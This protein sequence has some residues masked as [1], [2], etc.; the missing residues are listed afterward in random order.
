MTQDSTKTYS[1][2]G[3][4]LVPTI[5]DE[6]AEEHPESCVYIVPRTANFEDGF[7]DITWLQFA[8]AINSVARWIEENLGRSRTFETIAF[9][10]ATDFEYAVIT[11]A[12]QKAGY[13]VFSCPKKLRCLTHIT[14]GILLVALE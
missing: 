4:R 5:I 3:R 12:T 11:V 7:D 6:N 8:N 2:L 1:N 13:K 9:F 10:G 14:R